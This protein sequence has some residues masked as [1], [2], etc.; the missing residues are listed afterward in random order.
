VLFKISFQ[1]LVLGG[2]F[3]INFAQTD[4]SAGRLKGKMQR[5]KVHH[6]G[7]WSLTNFSVSDSGDTL[8]LATLQPITLETLRH[9]SD[10]AERAAYE[11]LVFAVRRIWSKLILADSLLLQLEG[12][13]SQ[14]KTKELRREVENLLHNMSK[15]EGAVFLKLIS[16]RSG[17]SAYDLIRSR[18]GRFRAIVYQ[19]AAKQ[20]GI[21]LKTT[22]NPET[23][24]YDKRL[25]EICRLV[26]LGI[27]EPLR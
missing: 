25:E 4:T 3:L 24:H 7:E 18:L 26:E 27:L 8:I 15:L 5:R 23:D 14:R 11:K 2:T 19:S 10:S 17:Q 1:L 16:R 13:T 21:D 12:Q 20:A 22:W 9:Y 6:F